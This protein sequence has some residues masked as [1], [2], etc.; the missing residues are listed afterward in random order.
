MEIEYEDEN[1]GLLEEE[2]LSANNGAGAGM[3]W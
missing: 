2:G 1:E 3:A